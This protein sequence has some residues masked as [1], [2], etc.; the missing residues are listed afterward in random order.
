MEKLK[1]NLSRKD[2]SLMLASC[3]N[4]KLRFVVIDGTEELVAFKK[5]WSNRDQRNIWEPMF[6]LVSNTLIEKMDFSNV[7]EPESVMEAH[8]LKF[9]MDGDLIEEAA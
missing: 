1:K 5:Y 8:N 4:I 2:M 6:V 9:Y 7:F 3:D